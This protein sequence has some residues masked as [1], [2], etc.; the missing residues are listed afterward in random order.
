[1]NSVL[2][3]NIIIFVLFSFTACQLFEDSPELQ[4]KKQALELKKL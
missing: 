4:E 1:M 2:K 3:I